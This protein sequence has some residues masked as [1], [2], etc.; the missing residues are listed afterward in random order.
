MATVLKKTGADIL[1]KAKYTEEDLV[2]KEQ[3]DTAISELL[4]TGRG[5]ENQKSKYL[6]QLARKLAINEKEAYSHISQTYANEDVAEEKEDSLQMLMARMND[7][8]DGQWTGAKAAGVSKGEFKK[9]FN[10]FPITNRAIEVMTLGGVS[11]GGFGALARETDDGRVKVQ[12]RPNASSGIYSSGADYIKAFGQPG[13][14]FN[15][16]ELGLPKDIKI[17]HE[18]GIVTGTRDI[19]ARLAPNEAVIPLDDP[20]TLQIMQAMTS[21]AMVKGTSN[22][23]GGGGRGESNTIIAPSTSTT[24]IKTN[25]VF[26]SSPTTRNPEKTYNRVSYQ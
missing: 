7:L 4:G 11:F 25:N 19:T 20:D 22:S 8:Y 16:E 23:G 2:G 10:M 26:T 12:T 9:L 1:G 18:G 3:S 15:P 5:D 6:L 14:L 21:N 17:M 13:N 24:S